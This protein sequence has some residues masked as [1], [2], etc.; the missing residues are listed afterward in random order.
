MDVWA[1]NNSGKEL[2]ILLHKLSNLGTNSLNSQGLEAEGTSPRG[3]T[4]HLHDEPVFESTARNTSNAADFGFKNGTL[5]SQTRFVKV[6]PVGTLGITETRS[7]A[8][9]KSL[10]AYDF[11]Q[12]CW[13][14]NKTYY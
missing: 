12:G 7:A 4:P 5:E 13:V 1:Y 6:L 8:S 9:N 11:S 2:Q 10:S 3:A 14:Y